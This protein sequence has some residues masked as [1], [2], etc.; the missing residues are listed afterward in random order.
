MHT[1]Y[2]TDFAH[3]T[4]LA[5]APAPHKLHPPAPHEKPAPAAPAP[6][7]H[8]ACTNANARVRSASRQSG[9]QIALRRCALLAPCLCSLPLWRAALRSSR[10]PPPGSGSLHQRSKSSAGASVIPPPIAARPLPETHAPPCAVCCSPHTPRAPCTHTPPKSPGNTS[11]SAPAQTRAPEYRTPNI[12][13]GHALRM[14]APG[15]P[16]NLRLHRAHSRAAAPPS[17][18]LLPHELIRHTPL[19]PRR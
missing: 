9:A 3:H 19:W 5:P 6:P 15:L 14:P 2:I 1:A 13:E 8:P 4:T 16:P 12:S 7:P 17:L 18:N 11:H 10:S